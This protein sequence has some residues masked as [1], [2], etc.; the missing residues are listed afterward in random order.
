MRGLCPTLG[1]PVPL[2]PTL[3]NALLA[4]TACM[5]RERHAAMQDPARSAESNDAPP[6]RRSQLDAVKDLGYAVLDEG[7][8]LFDAPHGRPLARTG[9]RGGHPAGTVRVL[10]RERGFVQIETRARESHCQAPYLPHG[11]VALRVWVDITS[12]L[13]VIRHPTTIR[14]DDGTSIRLVVG[15]PVG[16]ENGVN[17][18]VRLGATVVEVPLSDSAVSRFFLTV[19]GGFPLL[20]ASA[21]AISSTSAPELGGHPIPGNAVQRASR[22]VIGKGGN[23]VQRP[24]RAVI[25]EGGDPAPTSHPVVWAWREE[26]AALFVTLRSPCAEIEARLPRVGSSIVPLGMKPQL[27]WAIMDVDTPVGVADHGP[28]PWQDRYRIEAGGIAYWPNRGQAGDIAETTW[29]EAPGRAM[30]GRRC[31]DRLDDSSLV[32]CFDERDLHFE[33]ATAHPGTGGGYG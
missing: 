7:A 28:G 23:A 17:R 18:G 1:F 16:I 27:E 31:F 6:E 32:L 15:T 21:I 19:P 26:E 4:V 14:Y 25:G 29:F 22:A 5:A 12:L 33:P 11:G 3:L 9:H 2:R 20:G 8:V 30:D 24:P 10:A 13:P